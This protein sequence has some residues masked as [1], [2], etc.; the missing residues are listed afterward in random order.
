MIVSVLLDQVGAKYIA[1]LGDEKLCAGV[2]SPV[3]KVNRILWDRGET[4]I[5]QISRRET[6]SEALFCFKLSAPR[7]GGGDE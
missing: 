3:K 7:S 5:V 1:F 2:G 4:S 6:P